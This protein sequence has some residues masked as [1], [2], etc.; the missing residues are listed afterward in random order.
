MHRPFLSL[1]GPV[2]L[3]PGQPCSFRLPVRN[4]ATDVSQKQDDGRI[5]N[6]TVQCE[7]SVKGAR[8][9]LTLSCGPLPEGAA[10]LPQERLFTW[11]PSPSQ[12]G[13]HEILFFLDD[14]VLKERC[15]VIFYVRQK[16]T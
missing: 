13:R 7:P 10:F 12:A 4:P 1:D 6:E 3:A 14:G 2:V 5:Y 16:E 15:P 9:A 8:A 11:T